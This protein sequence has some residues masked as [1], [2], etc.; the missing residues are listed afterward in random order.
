MLKNDI[1][2]KN[3]QKKEEKKAQHYT[4]TYRKHLVIQGRDHA[5]ENQQTLV[6][7]IGLYRPVL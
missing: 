3:K 2:P 6:G 7:S 1:K 4:K 5:E